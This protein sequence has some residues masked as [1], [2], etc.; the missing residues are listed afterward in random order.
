MTEGL[1]DTIGPYLAAEHLELD[2]LEMVG[3]GRGRILRVVV[4]SRA[5]VDLERL[6]EVSQGLSRLLDHAANIEGSYELEVT[7][8]GLE[9]KLRRPHQ[10]RKATGREVVVKTRKT[11][12][13]L[14]MRGTL[15]SVD[16]SGFT[17]DTDE[18]PRHAN[19]EEVVSARTIFRWEKAGKPGH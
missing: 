17:V 18:G 11:D 5:G 6:A 16:A 19:F 3:T 8:P 15:A 12:Q 14:T 4:D 7:S 1:W 2:D 10:F 13:T 9:R